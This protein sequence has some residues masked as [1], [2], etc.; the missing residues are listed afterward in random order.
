MVA[1]T[2][3]DFVFPVNAGCH[4]TGHF[5]QVG[6]VQMFQKVHLLQQL[7]FLALRLLRLR[8]QNVSKCVLIDAE[9]KSRLSR[10]DSR[11]AGTLGK[12]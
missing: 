4:D 12:L 5:A 7:N 6:I 10:H 2:D 1:L 9:Q 3:N 11:G 8:L